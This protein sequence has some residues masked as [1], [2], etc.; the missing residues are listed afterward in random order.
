MFKRSVVYLKTACLSVEQIHPQLHILFGSLYNMNT[1]VMINHISQ[2]SLITY[3][4]KTHDESHQNIHS[5]TPKSWKR[6]IVPHLIPASRCFRFCGRFTKAPWR[7]ARWHGTPV[8]VVPLRKWTDN[9]R[10]EPQTT[11]FSQTKHVA[12]FLRTQSSIHHWCR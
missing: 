5:N 1:N 4:N 8:A 9:L 11:W 2:P 6:K 3:H 7:N 12:L 10:R